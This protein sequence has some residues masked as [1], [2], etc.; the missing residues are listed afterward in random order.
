MSRVQKRQ[1]AFERLLVVIGLLQSLNI[2]IS[3]ANFEKIGA[4]K[5]AAG[6]WTPHFGIEICTKYLDQ[7][8]FTESEADRFSFI[9]LHELGHAIQ[10][11]INLLSGA[12]VF[13]LKKI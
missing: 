7:K 10:D 6:T 13:C 5:G 12:K 11:A 9:L 8:K 4:P 3:P 2:K 1:A